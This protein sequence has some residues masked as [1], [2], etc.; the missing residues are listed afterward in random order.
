[1]QKLKG[2][3][4]NSQITWLE[5]S[6][7]ELVNTRARAEVFGMV[8]INAVWMHLTADERAIGMDRIATLL[9]PGGRL[10]MSLRHGPIPDGRR[11]FDVTGEETIALAAPYGLRPVSHVRRN[12]IMSENKARGV[13]WT[14]LVFEKAS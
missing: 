6:L 12:S 1:M 10:F 9:V 11:M 3:S 7:P 2:L 5:D 4:L 13:E 14:A 8:M